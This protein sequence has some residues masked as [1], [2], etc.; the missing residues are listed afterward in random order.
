MLANTTTEN[1]SICEIE[2]GDTVVLGSD[3]VLGRVLDVSLSSGSTVTMTY[4]E[5]VGSDYVV[6]GRTVTLPTSQRVRR[7]V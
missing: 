7:I 1:V 2:R 5:G 4:D 3:E 6:Y